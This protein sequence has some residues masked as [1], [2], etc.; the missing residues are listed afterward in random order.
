MD[1]RQHYLNCNKFKV[2]GVLQ[3]LPQADFVT[4]S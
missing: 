2:P 3:I 1:L 4:N